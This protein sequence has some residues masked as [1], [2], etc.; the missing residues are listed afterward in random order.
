MICCAGEP[1]QYLENPVYVA[2]LTGKHA[3]NTNTQ[4]EKATARGGSLP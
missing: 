1:C 3:Q 4:K 2:K